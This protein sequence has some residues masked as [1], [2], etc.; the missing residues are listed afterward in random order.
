MTQR[1][2]TSSAF[3]DTL[4]VNVHIS[5]GTVHYAE[6]TAVIADL[7]YL[8]AWNLRDGYNSY[9]QNV[10]SAIAKAGGKFDF[11]TIDGGS[12]SAAS[13]QTFL[14]GINVLSTAVPGSV[15]AVE[16]PNEINNWPLTWTGNL[17]GL[18]AAV[19]YQ[20]SLFTQAK[21]DTALPGVKVFY[22]TGYA[23]GTNGLG[24]N[25]A[26]TPGLADYD[27]Q[28]PYPDAANA[29]LQ[30]VNRTQA[31]PNE[32]PATG[33][34]VYT[35]TGYTS[36]QVSLQV[37]AKYTLDLLMD[38]AQSDIAQTYLYQLMDE[39]DGYGLFNSSNQPKPVATAI[40]NLTTI[41]ADKGTVSSSITPANFSVSGLPST[42][43]DMAIVK[44]TRQYRHRRLERTADLGDNSRATD[45]CHRGARRFLSDSQGVRSLAR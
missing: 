32:T 12:Q 9:W 7:Q 23:A 39:G 26:T 25:P 10:Y 29:P 43:H 2:M 37:Q 6:S 35:E 4:G 33:P 41:L 36:N 34:A 19:A 31:L 24:P 5:Q 3:A 15:A 8:N 11:L 27:T 42:G 45:Q 22:F 21:A 1:F 40:H 13:V 17:T 44:S 30:S 14:S 18:Q 28:H 16:G 38:N 20:A